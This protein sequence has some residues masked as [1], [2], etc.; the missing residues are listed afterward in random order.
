VSGIRDNIKRLGEHE[1][2]KANEKYIEV[3]FEYPDEEFEWKGFVPYHYPRGGVFA[4]TEDKKWEVLE[5][6]Y[7]AMHPSKKQ[8]WL[9]EQKRYWDSKNRDVT[10]GFFEALKDSQ[11]KC[12]NC[13]LP[14][15]PNFARRIQDLK[16]DGYT[17]ATDKSRYCPKCRQKV[18]HLLMLKLPRGKGKSYEFWSSKLRSRILNALGHRDAYE[19]WVR[20]TG[21]LPDH[22]FPEI[23]WGTK[24]ATAL[25][26]YMPLAEIKARFQLLTNQRNQQKREVCSNCFKTAKRGKLFGIDFFYEGDENWPKGVPTIG[27]KAED[28]CK[29]C[30]WY[31]LMKWREKL[32]ELIKA[33]KQSDPKKA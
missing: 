21:L 24:G 10:R 15:N 5:E 27:S 33:R 28:G 6:A 30:G 26:D 11:W 31:D 8:A 16:D 12:R 20:R 18:A 17:I 22:K 32:N 7:R 1:H 23:R 14:Q 2:S 9:N 3:I 19:N 13:D 29:G 25:P 4:T